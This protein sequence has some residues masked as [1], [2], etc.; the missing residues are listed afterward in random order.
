MCYV[1]TTSLSGCSIQKYAVVNYLWKMHKPYLPSW[2]F[3]DPITLL[4][5][6]LSMLCPHALHI[7]L[8]VRTCGSCPRFL[9]CYLLSF[10]P[11]PGR[12]ASWKHW[13]VNY[14]ESRHQSTIDSIRERIPQLPFLLVG[15]TLRH[16]LHCLLE[17]TWGTKTPL[18][19]GINLLI[20]AP[21]VTVLTSPSRVLWNHLPNKRILFWFLVC[22]WWN[23]NQDTY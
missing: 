16:D 21:L 4:Q 12:R 14:L 7:L 19:T 23:A 18:S 9:F 17:L 13:R 5:Q 1:E 20:N 22:F 3:T 8:T 2:N 6:P 11:D 10:P 15:K